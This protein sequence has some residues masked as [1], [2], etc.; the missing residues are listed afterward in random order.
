MSAVGVYQAEVICTYPQMRRVSFANQFNADIV[1]RDFNELW[2][3]IFLN[4]LRINVSMQLKRLE[5]ISHFL[6]CLKPFPIFN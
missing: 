4:L 6:G 1:F 5:A 3:K 2:I